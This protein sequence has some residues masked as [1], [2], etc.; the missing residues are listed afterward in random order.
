MHL[1]RTAKSEF[2]INDHHENFGDREWCGAA[3]D[4]HF[5]GGAQDA[6]LSVFRRLQ[7]AVEE[8]AETRVRRQPNAVRWQR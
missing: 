4:M 1:N 8:T 5:G 3:D 7:K 2:S 6:M